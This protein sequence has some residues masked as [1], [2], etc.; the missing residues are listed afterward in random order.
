M[1]LTVHPENTASWG[2][3]Q[4]RCA[5]GRGGVRRDK[6][7]GDGATPVGIWP[8]RR[9]LYRADRLEL[10]QT[11]LPA[12][13]IGATDGWC[14]APLDAAYNQPVRLPY[15]ASAETLWREDGVYDLIVPLGYN[16]APVVPGA[17]SAIFLHVAR[18]DFAPTEGCVAL[19]L[20]DLLTVLR[21]ADGGSHVIVEAG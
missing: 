2:S 10:P 19:A 9:L 13:A 8:M 12:S 3:L 7:E 17:G 21:E 15:P 16:D 1:N 11:T 5:I 14:D 6:R 4:L 18:P 20:A